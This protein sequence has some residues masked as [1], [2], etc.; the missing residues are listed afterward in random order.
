MTRAWCVW[1]W[2]C[3][4]YYLLDIANSLNKHAF[5]QNLYSW[6]VFSKILI[7]GFFSWTQWF[8]HLSTHPIRDLTLF[9]TQQTKLCKENVISVTLGNAP[10]AWGLT[11]LPVQGCL[12]RVKMGLKLGWNDPGWVLQPK[13]RAG[14]W[15]CRAPA[16]QQGSWELVLPEF[17]GPQQGSWEL[18][19]PGS[20]SPIAE[21]V[22]PTSCS[23]REELGAGSA[24]GVTAQP[25]QAQRCHGYAGA[26]VWSRR[27]ARS[28]LLCTHRSKRQ[29]LVWTAF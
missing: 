8:L 5:S 25:P 15:L 13:M 26:R 10:R 14:N 2:K 7:L 18:A 21:L 9:S 23:P 3:E 27:E 1:A 6:T 17:C 20:C 11:V 19:L 12:E 16:A 4:I 24:A 28:A 22:L 29:S